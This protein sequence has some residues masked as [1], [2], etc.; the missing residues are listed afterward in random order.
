MTWLYRFPEN[1]ASWDLA[2]KEAFVSLIFWFTIASVCLIY[3]GSINNPIE[4]IAYFVS[5]ALLF[6]LAYLFLKRLR[7]RS[8]KEKVKTSLC[9]I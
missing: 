1:K 3:G 8:L 4:M 9:L 7:S 2:L 5:I 6:A